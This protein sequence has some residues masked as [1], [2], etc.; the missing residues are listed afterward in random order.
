MLS[1]K[2]FKI[3]GAEVYLQRTSIYN[4]PNRDVSF[5]DI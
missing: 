4:L 1:I 3:R 2:N 5:P